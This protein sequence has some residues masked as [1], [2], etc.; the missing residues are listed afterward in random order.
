[1]KNP[2]PFCQK[3]FPVPTFPWESR[4]REWKNPRQSSLFP[5]PFPRSQKDG[6]G[7]KPLKS[8]YVPDSRV[9][10]LRGGISREWNPPVEVVRRSKT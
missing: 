2:T 6:N 3:S 1:M 10:P 9:L 8:L 7:Y 5:F 4:E